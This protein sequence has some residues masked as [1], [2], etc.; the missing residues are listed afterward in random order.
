MR[1]DRAALQADRVV[2]AMN[3]GCFA[4]SQTSTRNARAEE[5]RIIAKF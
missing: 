3:R 4:K 2:S 5:A 1:V